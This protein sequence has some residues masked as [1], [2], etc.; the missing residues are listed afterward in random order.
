MMS[1]RE[2]DLLIKLVR[3]NTLLKESVADMVDHS[4]LLAGNL[5]VVQ[6]KLQTIT[7]HYSVSLNVTVDQ[8]NV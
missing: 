8:K 6:D 5:S 7:E 4:D 3:I 2:K 1:E